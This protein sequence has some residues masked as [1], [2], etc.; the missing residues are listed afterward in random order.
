MAQSQLNLYNLAVS[1]AVGDY[2]ISATNEASLPAETCELWYENTRQVILRAAHWNSAKR[3]A[4][5][6]QETARN[7]AAD[8][9]TTDP[10][11]GYAYSYALPAN[12]LACRYLTTF[13]QFVLGYDNDKKIISCNS[14][15]TTA[16]E[17][18]VLCYTIDTTD[19]TLWEVD[20]YQAMVWGLAANI[21]L[22]LQG[23]P[24]RARVLFSF[25]N[26]LLL[27]ARANTANEM[28]RLMTSA[29]EGLALRGY[30][31]TAPERYIYPYGSLFMTPGAPVV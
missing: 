4:R 8:W 22:P 10:E 29:P 3:F 25:A 15:S 30:T 20:L 7:T 11:P 26:E 16:S 5:L 6:V 12:L 19:P 13:E 21:C 17:R 28:H 31:F 24:Q 27:Q 14:G 9:V 2:S 1:Q 18:P 23:K